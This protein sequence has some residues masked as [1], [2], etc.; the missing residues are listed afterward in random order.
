VKRDY[1]E[2]TGRVRALCEGEADDIA[3]MRGGRIVQQGA[4]YNVYNAPVDKDA[5]AF[6]SDINV[7][8]GTVRGALTGLEHATDTSAGTRAVLEG[9]AHALRDNLDALAATGTRIDS[10]I[11][12]GG[13][14]RSDYW[15][16]AIATALDLPVDLPEAGDFGAAL[17]AAR[18]GMM[19]ATGAGADIATAPR[20]AHTVAPD[21]TLRTA[22]ADA[23]ARYRHTYTA[24]KDLS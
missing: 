21:A 18:L 2:V 3:L 20:I 16:H 6:F 10:L 1:N 15:V 4:P 22:F 8:R 7:I 23:H 14:S 11:A 17:G 9:V 12:V 13:G 5:V 19:A 24:L